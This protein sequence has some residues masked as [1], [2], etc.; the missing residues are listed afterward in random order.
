KPCH[1]NKCNKKIGHNSHLIKH[2]RTPSVEKQ[3]GCKNTNKAGENSYQCSKGDKNFSQNDM[4]IEHQRIHTG[5]KAYQC[6][7][8]YKAFSRRGNIIKHKRTHTGEKPYTCNQC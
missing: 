2:Q 3:Y 4:L 5:E 1:F 8:C 7:Q 6:T